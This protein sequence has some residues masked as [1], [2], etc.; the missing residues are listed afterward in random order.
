MKR[1]TISKLQK[2]IKDKDHHPDLKKDYFLKLSEEVG[3]LAQ[4]IRKNATPANETSFKGSIEE[5]LYDVM[6]YT[7]A[8]ANLYDIDLETW[9]PVKER[10][11]DEKYGTHNADKL[12]SN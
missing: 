2:Y 9:I 8:I 3:E 4:A 12:F 11:N 5:E 10:I 7:L 6:Y 1:I